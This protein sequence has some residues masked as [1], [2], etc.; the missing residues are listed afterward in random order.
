MTVESVQPSSP[1]IV[2]RRV[3]GT[4]LPGHPTIGGRTKGSLN[5]VTSVMKEELAHHIEEKG[6]RANP[7]LVLA[8]IYENEEHPPLVRARA[9]EMLLRYLAPRLM[10]VEIDQP[11]Q[12][13]E[14]HISSLRTTLRGLLKKE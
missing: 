6:Q 5:K 10:Q 12:A 1:V 2:G 14:T 8:T 11:D 7:L 13:I 4:L 3:N 9:A